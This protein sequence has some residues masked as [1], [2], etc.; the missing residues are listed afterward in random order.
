MSKERTELLAFALSVGL[1]L[2]ED[3]EKNISSK[4]LQAK[5]DEKQQLIADSM[6][7]KEPPIEPTEEELLMNILDGL[8]SGDLKREE[9]SEYDEMLLS[10][11]EFKIAPVGKIALTKKVIENDIEQTDEPTETYE[12]E[13]LI[14]RFSA[15]G[16]YR[17]KIKGIKEAARRSGLT[18][19]E[20]K[21]GLDSG[22]PVKG[23][24][25]KEVE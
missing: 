12:D 3:F 6:Q 11:H 4:N 20:V 17:T 1:V 7:G 5:I 22:E 25:F 9:L 15:C 23:W 19:E 21:V 13:M 24:T 14:K 2:G 18:V 8:K 16:N 10:D